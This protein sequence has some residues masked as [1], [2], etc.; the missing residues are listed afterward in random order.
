M[1]FS[2]YAFTVIFAI[3]IAIDLS[4]LTHSN[5]ELVNNLVFQKLF[6]LIMLATI[7]IVESTSRKVLK[8]QFVFKYEYELIM[9]FSILGLFLLNSCEDLLMLY[10]AIELQSLSFYILATFH[11]TSEFNAEAGVKY[12]T[13]GALSSG[14]LLFGC[15]VVYLTCAT[16]SFE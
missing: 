14:F 10:L 5:T 9:L 13:L 4:F 7:I 16:T 15:A 8:K 6:K 12:F 2:I 1:L 3:A 11:K